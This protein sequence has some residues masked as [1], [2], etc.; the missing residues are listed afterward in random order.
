MKVAFYIETKPNKYSNVESIES[1]FPLLKDDYLSL[2]Q[3]LSVNHNLEIDYMEGDMSDFPENTFVFYHPIWAQ[4][5]LKFLQALKNP[6]FIFLLD[7]THSDVVSLASEIKIAGA[8]LKPS[9]INPNYPSKYFMVGKQDIL[10]EN[11]RGS[12]PLVSDL[13]SFNNDKFNS[14]YEALAWY[15]KEFDNSGLVKDKD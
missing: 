5:S 2:L 7:V 4:E 9:F 12:S 8:I 14:I 6:Q 1:Q 15:I 13:F 3:N 11:K 10:N